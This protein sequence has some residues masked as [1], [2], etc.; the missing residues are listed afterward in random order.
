MPRPRTFAYAL[1]LVYLDL[2]ELER[3]FAGRWLWSVERPNVVSFQRADYLGPQA[4]P[5]DR[6]VRERASAGVGRPLTGPVRMLTH[7][8]TLGH[9]FNPVTFYYCFDSADPE[10]LEAV[11]AEITNTPW[12]ERHAYVVDARGPGPAAVSAEGEVCAVFAKAFHVSPFLSLDHEY[13]WSLTVPGPELCVRMENHEAGRLV[14]E[15]ELALRREPLD[16]GALRRAL[17]RCPLG[18]WKVHAAIYWQALQLWLARTP[19]FPHPAKRP[20]GVPKR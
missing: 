14:F 5:L 1:H 13:R 18:T 8:R 12:G 4:L 10:R 3:V 17:V 15:A 11:V 19:F 9:A 6:A 20:A 16:A 7:L 2:D